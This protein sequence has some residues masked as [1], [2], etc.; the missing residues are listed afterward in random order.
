MTCYVFEQKRG[1][2]PI[3]YDYNIA[4]MKRKYNT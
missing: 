3:I 1:Y 2:T 4:F